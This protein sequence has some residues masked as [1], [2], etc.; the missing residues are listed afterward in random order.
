M[1]H[2]TTRLVL[3]LA[4]IIITARLA[5]FAFSRWLK[6]PRVLGELAAGMIIGPYALGSIPVPFIG[7]ALFPLTHQALPVSPEL[8][9]I[10]V[11]ASIVLLFRA[12]LETDLSVFLRYS[13]VGSVVGI[14]G[15]I[16][17]FALGDLI[18]VLW[19]I[20]PSFMSPAA[21][22]LGTV[23]AATS[24]GI[25][26]RIL[27]EKK[28]MSSPEGVTILSA[29]I[30]DDVL[31]IIILATVVG[32]AKAAQT[33]SHLAWAR[34]AVIAS[35]ALGFWLVCTA[36][37]ILFAPILTRFLK[38]FRSNDMIATTAFGVALLLAGLSEMAGLAMIIGA[39]V[40]GLSLSQ[41]DVAHELHERING[42]YQLFVPVFFCVMGMMVNFAAI[43]PVFFFGLAYAAVAMLG[44]LVGCG[45]PAWFFGFNL[46]GALRIG[47][48]MLPR[49][50]VTMIVAGVGLSSGIIGP[51]LFG[52]AVMTLFI[53]SA[54]APPV[55]AKLFERGSGV[56]VQMPGPQNGSLKPIEL[57]F[58]STQIADFM[59]TRIEQ[60]FRDEEFFVHRLD[61]DRP[62]CHIR[63]ENI[64]I[65]L[66]QDGGHITLNT[67]KTNE[68]LV[69]FIVLEEILELK[70]LMESMEK[71]KD[72]ASM[73][74][75]FMKQLFNSSDQQ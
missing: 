46:R 63:K 59:R 67:Q 45:L 29:A 69:R 75:D 8:Y 33:G 44:K 71:A 15:V 30:I 2:A 9:S 20:A 51:E 21:L 38:W 66:V 61:T 36:I 11:I 52:V 13:L 27:S 43:K 17:S 35:K 39:Y 50:E 14:S 56:R 24:V 22:F 16:I 28:K 5:G 60:A 6:Q 53:A 25:T 48:G 37:G 18:A 32:I 12:G 3:Q 65:T 34:I 42:V 26:A 7:K 57:Q 41:T 49:G 55:L 1:G 10:A 54:V 74:K 62:T 64:A 19:H 72:S 40:T 58:P 23:S 31:A 4:A 47:T 68:H 73:G 70:D